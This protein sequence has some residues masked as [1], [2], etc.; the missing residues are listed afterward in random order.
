MCN[1][2]AAVDWWALGVCLFEFMA[3]IPPF[4]DGTPQD[5]FNNILN[6]GNNF[7]C[8]FQFVTQSPLH[9]MISFSH[10]L[11]LFCCASPVSL[12]GDI[13]SF[14]NPADQDTLI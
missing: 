5:V 2:G 6:R 12:T 4:N 8:S 9:C 7:V 10:S 1:A 11:W 3:G 14:I 13:H